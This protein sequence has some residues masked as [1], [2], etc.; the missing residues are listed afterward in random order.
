MVHQ[1]GINVLAVQS[2]SCSCRGK[3]FGFYH[4]HQLVQNLLY[5]QLPGIWRPL[6]T[7]MSTHVHTYVHGDQSNLYTKIDL[8]NK[9]QQILARMWE[10]GKRYSFWVGECN[11][12]QPLWKSPWRFLQKLKINL[13]YVLFY[14]SSEYCQS[15]PYLQRNLHRHVCCPVAAVFTIARK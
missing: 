2:T 5:L 1:I 13:P 4:P 6:L 3:Q 14:R 10:T 9:W 15:S 7:A 11:S 12:V 8:Q